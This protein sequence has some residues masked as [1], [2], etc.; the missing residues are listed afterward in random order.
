MLLIKNPCW[1]PCGSHDGLQN[2]LFRVCFLI[3]ISDALLTRFWL[4]VGSILAPKWVPGG[5]PIAS[6]PVFQRM[7]RIHRIF[8]PFGS[9]KIRFQDPSWE[10]FG[11][12]D[13]LENASF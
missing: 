3:V 7:S 8:V 11:S 5:F 10:P 13:G 1:E 4:Q 6:G 2:A 12:H 9:L